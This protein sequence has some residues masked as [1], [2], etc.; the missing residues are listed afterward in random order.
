MQ[1]RCDGR[2]R[3]GRI[4]KLTQIAFNKIVGTCCP[5]VMQS[6]DSGELN[7]H[8]SS[9]DQRCCSCSNRWNVIEPC[10]Q[11]YCKFGNGWDD[12]KEHFIAKRYINAM[13]AVATRAWSRRRFVRTAANCKGTLTIH[14]VEMGIHVCKMPS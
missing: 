4:G 1:W 6:N 10:S 12:W 14:R 11:K 3:N 7:G 8:H 13:D 2:R 5:K 9:Q